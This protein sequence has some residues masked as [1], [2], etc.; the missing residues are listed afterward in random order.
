MVKTVDVA[1][2]FCLIF[3]FDNDSTLPLKED[4]YLLHICRR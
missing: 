2:G 4:K 1:F 3:T